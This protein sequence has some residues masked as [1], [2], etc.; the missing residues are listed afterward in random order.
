MKMTGLQSPYGVAAR[1][2]GLVLAGFVPA[3]A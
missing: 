2:T 3:I 1:R